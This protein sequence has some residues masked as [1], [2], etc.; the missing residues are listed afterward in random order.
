MLTDFLVSKYHLLIIFFFMC[1]RIGIGPNESHRG[2]GSEFLNYEKGQPRITRLF[3]HHLHNC[4]IEDLI[5]IG[6]SALDWTNNECLLE[7]WIT[8]SR[9]PEMEN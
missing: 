5:I 2:I 3:P 6:V 9:L 1:D 8:Y 7:N 4:L